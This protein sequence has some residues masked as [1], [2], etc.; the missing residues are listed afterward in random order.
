M[1]S[2]PNVVVVIPARWGSVRFPGKPLYEICEKPMIFWVIEKARQAKSASDVIVATDDQRI[3]DLVQSFGGKVVMTSPEHVSGS[4][5]IAEVASGLNC[6]IVVNVQGDE[7]LMPP[8]NVDRVVQALVDHPDIPVATIMVP[9]TS[10]EE[11]SDP[12]VV[13]VVV[14]KKGRALYFSRSPIPHDRDA[15]SAKEQMTGE[16]YSG[17][18]GVFKHL[19]LYAYRRSFLL[20]FTRMSPTPLEL[21][22]K[23]EQLRILENGYSLQV[24]QSEHDS[25]GVDSK[26]DLIKIEKILNSK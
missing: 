23:L 8:V 26:E 13:K 19:G 5:R 20:E 24:V 10:R 14:D 9:I 12:N 3:F 1:T 17:H 16:D 15:K 18:A 6:D 21:R 7:P 4:D 25:I 22:E 11:L 2:K